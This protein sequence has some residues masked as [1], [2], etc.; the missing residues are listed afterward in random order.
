MKP[1]HPYTI[2]VADDDDEDRELFVEIFERDER[3]TLQ[4]GLTSGM[5]VLDELSRKKN[6]PDVLLVDMYM[7]YFTG[8]DLVKALEELHAAPNMYKFVIST[9]TNIAE[10]ESQLN[11]PYIV[12]LKKPVS[13]NEIR[14]LPGLILAYMQQKL[15]SV[16]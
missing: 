7:P 4:G 9:T 12:F 6:I 11:S 14:E 2:L 16:S 3:F 13:I 8:V 15:A 1:L 5:E 10:N